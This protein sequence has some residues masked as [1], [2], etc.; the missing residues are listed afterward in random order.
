MQTLEQIRAIAERVAASRGLTIWPLPPK[1]WERAVRW[2]TAVSG[3]RE[4][5]MPTAKPRTAATTIHRW[6]T[7]SGRAQV[8]ATARAIPT[9][10][11]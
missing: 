10:P 6:W 9:T 5:G 11:A 2:G 7:T 4:S 1:A 8:A 3:T